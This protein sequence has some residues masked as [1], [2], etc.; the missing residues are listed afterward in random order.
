MKR[1]DTEIRGIRRGERLRRKADLLRLYRSSSRVGCE[2]LKIL[3]QRNDLNWNRVAFTTSKGFKGAVKRNREKRI[4]RE[5]Y[6]T[7]R[8]QI[9]SGYDLLFIFYPGKYS[10]S[11]R[12]EQFEKLLK[13]TRLLTSEY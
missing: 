13:R 8:G 12:Q 4:G 2:G 3:Y 6:R 11:G 10:F 9:K 7:R 5:I 1:N